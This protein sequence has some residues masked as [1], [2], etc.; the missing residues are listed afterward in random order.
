[1]HAYDGMI[2]A[3][4]GGLI[5]GMML[6]FRKVHIEKIEMSDAAI[7]RRITYLPKIKKYAVL[8]LEPSNDRDRVSLLSDSTSTIRVFNEDF[9]SNTKSLISSFKLCSLGR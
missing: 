2:L 5:F 1:L 8:C 9:E 6:D 7:P 4:K 3:T